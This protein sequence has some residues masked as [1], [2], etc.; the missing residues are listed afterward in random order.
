MA[1]GPPICASCGLTEGIEEHHLY[2]RSDGCPDYLTVWLCTSCHCEAHGMKNRVGHA[3]AVRTGLA[4][5][6][7]RGVQLGSKQPAI[8]AA[9]GGAARARLQA[10]FDAKIMAVIEGLPDYMETSF[11]VLARALNNRNIAAFRGGQWTARMVRV[12]MNRAA[13]A[14]TEAST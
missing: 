9:A 12:V 4:K 10:E 13:D 8:G 1:Y 7:A 6:R 3:E 11:T 14:R 2:L 5:A